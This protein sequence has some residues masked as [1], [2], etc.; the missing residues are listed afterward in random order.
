VFSLSYVSSAT[1]LMT[2]PQLVE[3]L[4]EI[5]PRNHRLELTG[6]L[7]YSGG[8]IVQALEGPDE[9]VETVFAAIESDPR[10]AEVKVVHRS[11]I[12]QRA[13]EDWSMGFRNVSEREVRDIDGYADFLRHPVG[14]GLGDQAGA[15]YDLLERFRASR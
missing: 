1:E 13:F 12:G 10:H 3:M 7:L 4:E 6:M 11:P 15:T 9:A 14:Q 8:N 2:V 5:R